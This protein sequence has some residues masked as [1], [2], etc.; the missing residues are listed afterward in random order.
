MI[1]IVKNKNVKRTAIK[2]GAVLS[3][4]LMFYLYYNHMSN[5]FAEQN[6]MLTTKLETKEKIER[7][8]NDKSVKIENTIYKEASVIVKLLEQKHVKSV[9]VVKER[10]LIVC[11]Y[12]TNIEPLLVRYGV[13]AMIK[14]T[15]TD[16]KIAIDLRT[17]VEN[18]Y[19]A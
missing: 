5:K 17:I 18:K 2:T 14:H 8:L 11:D 13:N 10:L 3:L 4:F 15:K 9:K 1:V 16:I 6:Q 12:S 7:K 19:E